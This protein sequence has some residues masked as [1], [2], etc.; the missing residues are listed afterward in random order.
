MRGM[1]LFHNNAPVLNL[2]LCRPPNFVVITPKI[3]KEPGVDDV[4]H[5]KK[6]Q[7][8]E[9]RKKGKGKKKEK[10]ESEEEEETTKDHPK[11]KDLGKFL[12]AYK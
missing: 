1:F 10:E 7:K 9:K 4:S 11:G 3:K 12:L 6:R 5:A 8:T 2:Y